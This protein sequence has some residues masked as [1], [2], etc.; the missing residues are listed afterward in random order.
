[1]QSTVSAKRKNDAVITVCQNN[2]SHRIEIEGA[3]KAAERLTGYLHSELQDKELKIIL[4]DKIR[5]I[6]ESYLEFEDIGN[7]LAAVLRKVPEFRILNKE[8]REIPVSLKVFYVIASHAEKPQFELLMRDITLLREMEELRQK[9]IESQKESDLTEYADIGVADA[10]LVQSNLELIH[11][12][13]KDHFF[14]ASFTVMQVDQL[15][16][17]EELHGKGVTNEVLKH[18][19][20]ITRQSLREADILGYMGDGYIGLTLFDC[21]GEDAKLVL[22][23]LRMAIESKPV[24]DK[25]SGEPVTVSIGFMQLVPNTEVETIISM[26]YDAS[27]KARDAGGNRIYKA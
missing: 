10:E 23:R 19:C 2:R 8:G 9:I 22:N 16:T 11:S 6:L 20:D 26:C 27:Q 5:D 14:E 25:G 18:V 1:M 21:N 3:N 17:L 24:G 12:F 13:V 7:D 4:P 15:A